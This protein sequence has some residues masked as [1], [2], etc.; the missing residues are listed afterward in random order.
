MNADTFESATLRGLR[1]HHQRDF[2]AAQ[3]VGMDLREVVTDYHG[4]GEEG[5]RDRL[6]L[7]HHRLRRHRQG[8]SPRIL[9]RRWS[10]EAMSSIKIFMTYDLLKVDDETLLDILLA[11]RAASALVCVHAENHGIDRLDGEAR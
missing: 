5:R 6:R 7:P 4:A 1:R 3:H 9:V 11:A 8:R 2:F 10:A